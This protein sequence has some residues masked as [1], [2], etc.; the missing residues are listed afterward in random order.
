[1]MNHSENLSVTLRRDDIPAACFSSSSTFENELN[2][3]LRYLADKLPSFHVLKSFQFCNNAERGNSWSAV[4]PQTAEQI[5]SSISSLP[6]EYVKINMPGAPF[7]SRSRMFY[8]GLHDPHSCDLIRLH[9]PDTEVF[10]LCIREICPDVLAFAQKRPRLKKILID[11]KLEHEDWQELDVDANV[12]DCR[13]NENMG[14]SLADSLEEAVM[15]CSSTLA[16]NLRSFELIYPVSKDG[17]TQ[18]LLQFHRT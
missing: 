12:I 18:T 1:M 3:S 10:H 8:L 16:P 14:K 9:F 11:L 2:N 15:S 5:L 13:H 17:N 7:E 6:L 4:S